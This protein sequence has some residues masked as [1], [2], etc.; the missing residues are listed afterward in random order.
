MKS[1]LKTRLSKILFF[2]F[3]FIIGVTLVMQF[4]LVETMNN[5]QSISDKA[6]HLQLELTGIK[7]RKEKLEKEI[8]DVESKIAE[9]NSSELESNTLQETLKNEMEK[10]ELQIGYRK[11]EG[12]GIELELLMQDP[13][14]YEVLINNYDL[15]LSIINKLNAAGAEG[16]AINEERYVNTTFF[17][18]VGDKL[19]VNGN[20]SS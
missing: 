10:Y 19:Y 9:I 4:K 13:Q 2:V 12:E 5:G 11:A 17:Q 14:A 7:E 16:I 8:K 6:A 3:S 20:L 18:L 15:I 1:F